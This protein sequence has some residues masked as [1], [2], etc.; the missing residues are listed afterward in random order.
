MNGLIG[1]HDRKLEEFFQGLYENNTGIIKGSH[2]TQI[3]ILKGS[4]QDLNTTTVG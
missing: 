4:L 3:S 1:K 2:C